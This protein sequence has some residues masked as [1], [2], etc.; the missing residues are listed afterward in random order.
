VNAD[1]AL[2]AVEADEDGYTFRVSDGTRW[3][4]LATIERSFFSTERAGGFVGVYLGL[5]GTSNGRDSQGRARIH[6]FEYQPNS[7]AVG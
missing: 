3:I 1:E 4:S 7:E 6:W 5:Y 2:L